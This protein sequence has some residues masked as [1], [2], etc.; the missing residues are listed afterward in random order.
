MG[1]AELLSNTNS[2]TKP[3]INSPVISHIRS[4]MNSPMNK[5]LLPKTNRFVPDKMEASA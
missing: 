3:K 2:I 5:K 4:K 1:Y